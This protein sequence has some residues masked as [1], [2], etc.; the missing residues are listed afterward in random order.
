MKC[1]M[2][3]VKLLLKLADTFRRAQDAF[4][5]RTTKN[6]H[7]IMIDTTTNKIV[8]GSIWIIPEQETAEKRFTPKVFYD[9]MEKTV[10]AVVGIRCRS[11]KSV[12]P[13]VIKALS[14]H[15]NIR[16]LER[17][18]SPETVRNILETPVLVIPG[19]KP[20]TA[21]YGMGDIRIPVSYTGEII[22]CMRREQSRSKK[23]R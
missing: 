9:N 23:K 14:V 3:R 5:W 1:N 20:D 15:A 18:I 6:G 12:P 11:S 22:T 17:K 10:R 16:M 21:V 4:V 8:A 2:N 7:K 19:A 13:I